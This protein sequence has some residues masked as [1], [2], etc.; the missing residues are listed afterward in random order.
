MIDYVIHHMKANGQHRPKVF[1]WA[2]KEIQPGETLSLEKHH[3]VREITT[4]K[5]YPGQH[6]LEVQVNGRIVA[7]TAFGLKL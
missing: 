4:R 3:A 1:K 2:K 5:Y 7:E 6:K